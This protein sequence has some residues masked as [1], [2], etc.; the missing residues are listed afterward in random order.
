MLRRKKS[1]SHVDQ[2]N[3]VGANIFRL[4]YRKLKFGST[5]T[6]SWTILRSWLQFLLF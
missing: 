5:V 4:F 1:P 3:E 2:I 6:Y